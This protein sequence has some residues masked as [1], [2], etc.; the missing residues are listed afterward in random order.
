MGSI[1]DKLMCK[2]SGGRVRRKGRE[3]GPGGRDWNTS[4]KR[5]NPGDRGREGRG[6]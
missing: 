6:K 4:S 3:E 2:G 1:P 5:R